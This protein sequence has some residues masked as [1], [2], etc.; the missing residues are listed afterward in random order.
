MKD[1]KVVITKC[2]RSEVTAEDKQKIE[3]GLEVLIKVLTQPI[4]DKIGA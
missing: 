1:L 4:K 2:K 3:H